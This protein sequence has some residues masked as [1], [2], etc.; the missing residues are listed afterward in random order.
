MLYFLKMCVHSLAWVT[1]SKVYG[2][3]P[4]LVQNNQIL[5]SYFVLDRSGSYTFK[6]LDF[7]V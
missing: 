5:I 4:S 6:Y 1:V 2:F 3:I 7:I